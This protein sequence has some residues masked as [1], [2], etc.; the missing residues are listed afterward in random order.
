MLGIL[1]TTFSITPIT[2]AAAV[3]LIMFVILLWVMIENRQK[4]VALVS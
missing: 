4:Y 2:G 1:C 3:P